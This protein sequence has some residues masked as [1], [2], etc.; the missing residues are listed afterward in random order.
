MTTALV[1]GFDRFP[2]A[3]RNPSA[4]LVRALAKRRRPAFADARI[5]PVVLPT[6]Y[7][8]VERDL[9]ALLKQYDPD[10]VLFF[11]L[12]S[13]AKYAR[14]ESRAVNAVTGF[15]P[16]A[17]RKKLA[18]RNFMRGAP[19][20][21][22][23]R[24]PVRLLM[25]AGRNAGTPLR[26]SRDAG[27]YICNAA[28]FTGLDVARRSGRPPFVAF[29]HIPRP[30]ARK[31]AGGQRRAKRPRMEALIRAGSAVLVALIAAARRS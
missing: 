16:D 13:R 26:H 25:A 27:R 23:V 30:R 21:L 7:E 22:K 4:D 3:P 17:A 29:V 12:A 8:A 28:L 10:I 24:A 6:T 19:D 15:Y 1:I 20:V 5:V 9:P 11:G 2:G 31:P 14:V 18:T